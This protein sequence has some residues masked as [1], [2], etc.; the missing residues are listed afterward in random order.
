VLDWNGTGFGVAWVSYTSVYFRQLDAM[1]HLVGGAPTSN[2]LVA[3]PYADERDAARTRIAWDPTSGTFGVLFVF[4]SQLYFMRVNPT[5]TVAL[6]ARAIGPA[7]SQT[8][9]GNFTALATGGA[10]FA[11]YDDNT[12]GTVVRKL[13]ADGTTLAMA[14]VRPG[15]YRFPNM[16]EHAGTLYVFTHDA[17]TVGHVDAFDT[18]LH[19]VTAHSGRIGDGRYMQYP[20]AALDASTGALSVVYLDAARAV[21]FQRLAGLP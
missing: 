10:F 1:R 17:S 14:M 2:T 15:E 20:V 11:A 6:A 5:G 4:T 12:T 3:G 21:Q 9:G 18:A 16:L 7:Y 8:F 13:G 19:P